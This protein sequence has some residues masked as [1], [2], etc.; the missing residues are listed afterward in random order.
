MFEVNKNVDGNY[1]LLKVEENALK[2]MNFIY[3]VYEKYFLQDLQ[4]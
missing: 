1:E 3:Q 2:E 4:I